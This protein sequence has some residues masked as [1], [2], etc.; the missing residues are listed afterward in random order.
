MKFAVSIGADVTLVISNKLM[1][2][3]DVWLAVPCK[4]TVFVVESSKVS[5]VISKA[6]EAVSANDVNIWEDDIEED[7]V[8]L[9]MGLLVSEVNDRDCDVLNK[10][11]LELLTESTL[12]VSDGIE[13][14][15]KVENIMSL[16]VDVKVV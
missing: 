2:S 6:V 12:D 9:S 4:S 3:D 11:K 16:G 13:F 10:S 7:M 5:P 15:G 14:V 1:G 8:P